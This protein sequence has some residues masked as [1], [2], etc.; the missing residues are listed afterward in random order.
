MNGKIIYSILTKL[1]FINY[2]LFYFCIMAGF[3]GAILT[4]MLSIK[5]RKK[6]DIQSLNIDSSSMEKQDFYLLTVTPSKSEKIFINRSLFRQFFS[7]FPNFSH[8]IVALTFP[9][10]RFFATKT[11]MASNYF[12]LFVVHYFLFNFFNFSYEFSALQE[13]RF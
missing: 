11:K 12:V 5:N 8:L 1:D 13:S 10:P 6:Q 2:L 3:C 9:L 4:S 7:F